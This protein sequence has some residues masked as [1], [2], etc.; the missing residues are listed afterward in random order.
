M[1]VHEVIARTLHASGVHVLFGLMGDANMLHIADFV[2]AEGGRYVSAVIEGGAV[3]MADGY[4]RATGKVGVATVTHGPGITNC[5]T[6]LT[7]AVRAS[8]ALVVLCGDPLPRRQHLQRL[9]LAAIATAAGAR[10]HEVVLSG[11][12]EGDLALVLSLAVAD[13]T[14]VLVN[15]PAAM[16]LE[17]VEYL[18][19]G[20][21]LDPGRS[22]LTTDDAALDRAIGVIASARCPV[23]LAGRGAVAA[24]ALD[25]IV[26][27]A[28]LI[29]APLATTVLARGA[30]AG[31]RLDVGVM[32]TVAS[33]LALEVIGDADCLVVFGASL[34]AHTT[35]RDALLRG[36][37]VVQCDDVARRL[38]RPSPTTAPLLGDARAVARG[39]VAGLRAIGD[40]A[41]TSGL[42]ALAQ[43]IADHRPETEF[44]DASTDLFVDMR[45]ALIALNRVLPPDRVIVFDGGRFLTAAF[46]YLDV[47]TPSSVIST[48][49]F[50]AIGL[51]LATAIGASIGV[52]PRLTVGIVGDGGAM[53][54]LLELVTAVRL[55]LPLVLVVLNDGAYGAEYAKLVEYGVD[56]VHSLLD[57]PDL[58]EV[59]HA[60]G[61]AAVT[62]RSAAE[63]HAV[64]PA[65]E[66]LDGPL[67][68]D[69]RAD[70]CVD[71]TAERQSPRVG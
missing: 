16:Q 32:G 60:L 71:I 69:I 59:A 24:G 19:V 47:A 50:A 21:A 36:K 45:T 28:D 55:R 18:G 30:F 63:L 4:S 29:G 34:S 62:I 42:D 8:S 7:E 39:I 10:Y 5:L 51:G 15:I 9:D 17:D 68:I 48:V 65:L 14:P 67:V 53:M 38:L 40:T 13:R 44:E 23:V 66:A 12:V 33:S 56:P 54:G 20:R 2:D 64:G 11:H 31:H 49:N 22:A 25:D 37:A 70:P 43:R 46:K 1:K 41:R 58:A 35:D 6:A 57:L 26:E 61:A 3:G 52:S 27:L